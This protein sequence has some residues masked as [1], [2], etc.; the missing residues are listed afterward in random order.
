MQISMDAQHLAS[1]ELYDTPHTG[2]R[3]RNASDE[4]G[5]PRDTQSSLYSG[6]YT[7]R[8][9][10]PLGE[11]ARPSLDESGERYGPND[12][13]V[14]SGPFPKSGGQLKQS[15][16]F[17]TA[18]EYVSSIVSL[19]TNC[20]SKLSWILAEDPGTGVS[21]KTQIQGFTYLL[22]VLE[23]GARAIDNH[24][25]RD[26]LGIGQEFRKGDGEYPSLVWLLNEADH[27]FIAITIETV[28]R[29]S[30][31]HARLDY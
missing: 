29:I 2:S 18:E 24:F 11:D 17:A 21:S 28:W 12:Y 26:R 19:F 23:D 5:V 31:A 27:E 3:T 1:E 30:I 13:T 22:G 25:K 20:H 16:E 9:N 15:R 8:P 7:G 10:V 6:D 4:I 14:L